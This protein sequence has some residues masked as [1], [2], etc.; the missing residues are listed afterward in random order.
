[1]E[2]GTIS[3]ANKVDRER[4]A[5]LE[6]K[7][8]D[9]LS[10][11]DRFERRI[12]ELEDTADHEKQSRRVAEERAEIA[13]Q[14]AEATETSYSRSLTDYAD[15]QRRSKNNEASLQEHAERV[16]TLGSALQRVKAE[17]AHAKSRLESSEASLDQYLRTLEQTQSTLTAAN[18]QADEMEALWSDAKAKLAEQQ[19]LVNRLQSELAEKTATATDATA[20]AAEVERVLR[21]TREECESMR[22]LTSGGL[23]ELVAASRD[24]KN[25]GPAREEELHAE[26][27][28]AAEEEL[29][30]L[31]RLHRE[32][33]GR[34]DTSHLELSDARSRVA[35]LEK[36]V[37]GLRAEV[38][39]LRAQHA[40]ALDEVGQHKSRLAERE[41]ELRQKTRTHE[42]S[43]MKATLMRSLLVENGIA[44][45][46]Y[47]GSPKLGSTGDS[48]MEQMTRRVQELEARLEQR[49]KSHRDLETSQEETKREAQT[50]EQNLRDVSRY[51]QEA[52]D[53]IQQLSQEVERLRSGGSSSRGMSDDGKDN[54][55]QALQERH[56]QLE[57]T[58]VKAVSYVKGVR[59]F[60]RDFY[61]YEA[62]RLTYTDG[63]DAAAHEG[64]AHQVQG[65]ERRARGAI[66]ERPRNAVKG[67]DERS[68]LFA[69]TACRP[70]EY[71]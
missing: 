12:S 14:R 7:L 57:Q 24:F 33:K 53:Q 54:E 5:D 30:N 4:I 34:A 49:A 51:R 50:A 59:D 9:A 71:L 22:S 27:L 47:D 38:S 15:L 25:R 20:R 8:A 40:T 46:D 42:A 66:G 63:E 39:T 48:S 37:L 29:E 58:H 16:S 70:P 56:R 67:H 18:A 43:E 10:E 6:R 13:T 36:Q 69:N 60:S 61:L 3:D 68:R 65:A 17:H 35:Q 41:S 1:L 55:L 64:R 32:A 2:S 52:D 62:D 21:A 23:A 19:A 28:R 11:R 45:S 31:R 26:R 44:V